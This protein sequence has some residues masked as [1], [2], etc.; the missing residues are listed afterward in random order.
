MNKRRLDFGITF[1]GDMSPKRTVA[2]TKMAEE[3]GFKHV[4]GFDSHVLW[5]DPY[6]ILALLAANTSKVR[7][8]TMVTNPAV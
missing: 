2:L 4:W 5:K 1:K 6:P 7:L 8:G 3:A